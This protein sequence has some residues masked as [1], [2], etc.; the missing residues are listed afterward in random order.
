MRPDRPLL[1]LVTDRRRLDPAAADPGLAHRRLIALAQAAVTAGVD[2][3]QVRERDL[4]TR[5]LM[6]LV[7]AILHAARGSTTQVVVNDR[8]D[9]AI[10]CGAAGVHLRS[11]SMPAARVRSLV[12]P[13]FLVGRS[14]HTAD[15]A[16]RS[17]PGA[18]YLIAGTVF[19]TPSK[20]AQQPLLG[21]RGL[22]AIVNAVPIPVLAIGGI[23]L[24]RAAEVAACGTAGLAAI[25]LF[26]SPTPMAHLVED[27][28][29]TFDRVR[30]GS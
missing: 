2:M 12:P 27:V 17:A 24:D 7:E 4:D 6:S 23:T 21:T 19:S 20:S 14:V 15:E 25:R 30:V 18:D 13:G 10:A 8:V 26:L 16:V 28:R 22:E 9:V 29:A 5:S 11:D 3:I 1:C